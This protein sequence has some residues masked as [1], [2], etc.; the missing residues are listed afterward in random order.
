MECAKQAAASRKADARAEA[1]L[2]AVGVS[3][4]QLASIQ[5]GAKLDERLAM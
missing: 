1:V 4:C 3:Q 2:V 5:G